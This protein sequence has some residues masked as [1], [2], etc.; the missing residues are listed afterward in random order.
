MHILLWKELLLLLKKSFVA[1]DFLDLAEGARVAAA[2]TT[3]TL[4]D[5]AIDR[6]LAFKNNA[7]FIDCISK[8]N[9]VLI[10]NAEDLDVLMSDLHV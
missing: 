3:N 9:G 5:P 4:N 10:D 8:V 6:R 1:N 7:P 2:V